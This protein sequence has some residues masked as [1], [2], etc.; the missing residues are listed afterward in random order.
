VLGTHFT[1]FDHGCNPKENYE[2]A[3]RE[4][5]GTVY[6]SILYIS[7]DLNHF[8]SCYCVILSTNKGG[9]INFSVN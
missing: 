6:V 2:N 3:R 7:G 9:Q 5:V 4:L 8:L 1:L